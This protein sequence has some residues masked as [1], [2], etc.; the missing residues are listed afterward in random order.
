MVGRYLEEREM[1]RKVRRDEHISREQTRC[2]NTS[3]CTCLLTRPDPR[4]HKLTGCQ[5]FLSC[6]FILISSLPLPFM[7][8]GD[9]T[10]TRSPDGCTSKH[11]L[12][13]PL[14]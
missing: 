7:H 2:V 9:I 14:S 3:E 5:R 10:L 1:R 4:S 6:P 11:A 8:W 12:H 13:R